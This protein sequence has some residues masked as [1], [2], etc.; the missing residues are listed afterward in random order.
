FN[1]DGCR[2]N[3]DIDA[4]VLA[5]TDVEVWWECFGNPAIIDLIEI[6]DCS[7]DG[8][9]NNFDIDCMVDLLVDTYCADSFIPCGEVCEEEGEQ[10]RY[11]DT[12]EDWDHFW[13]VVAWLHEY[14]EM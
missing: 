13:S 2:N 5:V 6:G 9:V 12:P 8:Y 14:F 4:F 3:Y 7:G 11:G 1:G 10:A